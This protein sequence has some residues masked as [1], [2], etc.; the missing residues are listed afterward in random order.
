MHRINVVG[1]TILDCVRVLSAEPNGGNGGVAALR[2][3]APK[4][5]RVD[6]ISPEHH[7][8]DQDVGAVGLLGAVLGRRDSARIGGGLAH[9]DRAQSTQLRL[10]RRGR[11]GGEG[12]PSG[13]ECGGKEKFLGGS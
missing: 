12:E 10:S 8:L 2:D 6:Q 5:P 9:K 7:V 1:A 13:V 3:H 4:R 11:V